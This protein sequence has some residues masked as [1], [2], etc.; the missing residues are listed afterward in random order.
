MEKIKLDEFAERLSYDLYLSQPV[1]KD[2][3]VA[4]HNLMAEELLKDK[5]FRIAGIGEFYLA[6]RP[7]RETTSQFGDSAGEP[8]HIPQSKRPAFK[9]ASNFKRKVI[10]TYRVD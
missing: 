9:F 6:D 8:V 7:A 5:T 2:V 4:Y 3:L 1:V 10:D